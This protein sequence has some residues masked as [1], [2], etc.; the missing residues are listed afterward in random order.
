MLNDTMHREVP[1]LPAA[2]VI[3]IRDAP[4]EVLMLRR[5]EQSSF[6]PNAWVFPGGM[7]EAA[8]RELAHGAELEAMKL[9]GVRE[10]FEE[11]GIWLG[12]TPLDDAETKRRRLLNG[13]L[14]FR[15][16]RQESPVDVEQ[17][18][19][20]S[21]WITPIGIPKRFDTWFFLA[22]VSRDVIASA[23]KVE[24]VEVLWIAPGEAL[25]KQKARELQMVF[26]T[27]KN[28]EAIAQYDSASALLNARRGAIIEPILPVLVD[29]KPRLP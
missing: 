7:A 25:A 4:L 16:L 21:R 11:A 23:E 14:S 26:P 10:T 9:A 24:A 18:V 28:L 17:L 6:V 13:E 22:E 27:I 15:E 8:D 20:T 2:S 5:H 1:A 12:R 19:W 3:V 29:G